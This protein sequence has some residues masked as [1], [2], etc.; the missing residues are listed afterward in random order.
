MDWS[1]NENDD[2]LS[3]QP[4]RD[5]PPD[6]SDEDIEYMHSIISKTI[7]TNNLEIYEKKM[8]DKPVNIKKQKKQTITRL[9]F[10]ETNKNERKFNP[11]LPPPD[12]YKKKSKSY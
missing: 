5:M 11:R 6:E 8:L 7:K 2:V 3:I 4:S 12:K 10:V 9:I 1:D